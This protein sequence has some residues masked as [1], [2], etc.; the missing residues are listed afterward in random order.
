MELILRSK[1][2]TQFTLGARAHGPPKRRRDRRWERN[3][4]RAR[5]SEREKKGWCQ[6]GP[7]TKQQQEA[8]VSAS[9]TVGALFTVHLQAR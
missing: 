1:P 4:E 8:C 2:Q 5:N 6:I 3:N 7:L 9:A